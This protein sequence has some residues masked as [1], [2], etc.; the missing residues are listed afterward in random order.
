MVAL[1]IRS[2]ILSVSLATIV[3][4]TTAAPVPKQQDGSDA[5]GVLGS[6]NATDI[7]YEAVTA[8]YKSIPFDTTVTTSTMETVYTLFNEYY[9]FRDSALSPNLMSPFSSAPVDIVNTLATI[10]KTNYTSD[11]NF[12]DDISTAIQTLHDAHAGYDVNC[13]NAYMFEQLLALYAPVINGQQSLR[14]FKDYGGRGY[15]DCEVLK[16]DGQ[17]A[18]PYIY[19]WADR[20]GFSKDGG[21][22]QNQALANQVYNHDLG[23]FITSS[24]D[25]AQRFRLPDKAY[26][27]YELNCPTSS[28]TINLRENWKVSPLSQASFTDVNSYL[29][30]VCYSTP[31]STSNNNMQKRELIHPTTRQLYPTHRK[32]TFLDAVPSPQTP[33]GLAMAN[34]LGAGNATVYYQL[35]DKLDVG[36]IVVFT[37]AAEDSELDV[38]LNALEEFQKLNVT[39]LIFDF[40]G[41][42]GGSVSFASNL[43][44]LF[45]P[46]K[47]PLDKSLP[48]D[49]RVSKTNQDLSVAAFNTSYG[50]LY[51]ASGYID[52]ATKGLY[53]NDSLFMDPVTLSR[54]GRAT[55]YSELTTLGTDS[56]PTIKELGSFPWTN[57]PNNIR[58]LSD[59]RCG[60]SCALSSHYLHTLYNVTAYSV[61]GVYGQEL[62]FFSFAGGAVSSLIDINKIYTAANVSSDLKDL[63]YQNDVRLPILEVYAR[64]SQVPLEYDYTQ[65]TANFHLDFDPSNA[66]SH[67]IMW[68]QVASHAWM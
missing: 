64:E 3:T 7:T 40:Q 6:L 42:G 4:L 35:K 18:L 57:N 28:A 13:Y 9:V 17:D 67:D 10:G 60:S 62:S 30:N 22:R 14:V 41:N 50:G 46:N 23:E 25:F 1:S 33:Q 54:N 27:D 51:D 2:L 39:K 38:I 45:F 56:L 20:L 68:D 34:K 31:A 44:Q 11:F 36:V 49:L 12:H 5:C 66:R 24:G 58:L 59:G 65:Y 37:H 55:Q 19:S 21:V 53:T 15:E 8:C 48:S 61:G 43:V 63:P 32:S 29:A 26:I 47:G 52:L 16:I